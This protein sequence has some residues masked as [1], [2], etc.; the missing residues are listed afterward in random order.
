MKCVL[1]IELFEYKNGI[2]LGVRKDCC[3]SVECKDGSSALDIV[4]RPALVL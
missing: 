4:I 3:R 2:N 1:D